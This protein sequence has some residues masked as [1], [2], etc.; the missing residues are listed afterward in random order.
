[1]LGEV[2]CGTIVVVAM[3]VQEADAWDGVDTWDGDREDF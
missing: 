3:L 2:V 1:M